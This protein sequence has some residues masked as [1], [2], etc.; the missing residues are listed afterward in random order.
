MTTGNGPKSIRDV[1]FEA[2]DLASDLRQQREA[3]AQNRIADPE[4]EARRQRDFEC[5]I[6]Q[7]GLFPR[8]RGI[9]LA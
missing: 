9:R 8:G 1:L 6:E 3:T 7:I 4:K 5:S 2:F